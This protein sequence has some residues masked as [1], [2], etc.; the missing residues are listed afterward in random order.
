MKHRGSELGVFGTREMSLLT[1]MLKEKMSYDTTQ[2]R[3][4]PLTDVAII[5][6]GPTRQYG[7]DAALRP[8]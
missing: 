3:P 1:W 4:R 7:G 6:P 8:P 2:L 5:V